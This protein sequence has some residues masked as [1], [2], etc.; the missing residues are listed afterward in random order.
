MWLPTAVTDAP[1]GPAAPWPGSMVSDNPAG[2]GGRR[3]H[4]TRSRPSGRD[5]RSSGG[6]SGGCLR[7]S[8]GRYLAPEVRRSAARSASITG[9]SVD[10]S[11]T[12]G[13]SR[14]SRRPRRSHGDR[15]RRGRRGGPGSR[16]RGDDHVHDRVAVS[17][18]SALAGRRWLLRRAHRGCR[19]SLGRLPRVGGQ[20]VQHPA[21]DAGRG[22]QEAQQHGLG[23]VHGRLRGEDAVPSQRHMRRTDRASHVSRFE[24]C[25]IR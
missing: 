13:G 9:A 17:A 6:R 5:E 23:D 4:G 18:V 1:G 12:H 15:G 8:D 21:E 14:R 16:P 25:D 22:D 11:H 24:V 7:G 3:V 20:L 19:P 10:R 2:A